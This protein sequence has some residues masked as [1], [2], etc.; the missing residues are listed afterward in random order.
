MSEPA[1]SDAPIDAELVEKRV[2]RRPSE[3]DYKNARWLFGC[4]KDVNP[5]A[6]TPNFDTWAESVRLMREIDHRT[7]KD[8]AALFRFAKQDPFWS[9]NIQSP[10]KLREKWDQL[11]ELRA[12]PARVEAPKLNKQEQLEADNRAVVA[13]IMERDRI[14]NETE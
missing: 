12:R 9:P 1:A 13:R 14:K 11:T 4:Q 5:D 8:I 7:H 10:A 3:D 6:K 2:K